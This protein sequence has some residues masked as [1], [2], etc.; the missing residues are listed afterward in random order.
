[1]HYCLRIPEIRSAVFWQLAPDSSGIEGW[2]PPDVRR[3]LAALA[4]TCKAFSDG[5]LDV[6]WSRQTTLVPFMKCLPPDA[7]EAFED[8]VVSA[9]PAE[10]IEAITVG[11]VRLTRPIEHEEWR[12][13]LAYAFRVRNLLIDFKDRVPVSQLLGYFPPGSDTKIPFPRIMSLTWAVHTMSLL[14]IRLFLSPS[15][16]L[17]ELRLRPLAFGRTSLAWDLEALSRLAVEFQELRIL[18][19]F[20]FSE[21]MDYA[22]YQKIN[23][24]LVTHVDQ[25]KQLRVG[26][27]DLPSFQH[28]TRLPSL[29]NLEVHSSVVPLDIVGWFPPTRTTISR[30]LP[31]ASLRRLSLDGLDLPYFLATQLLESAT[32]WALADLD[33][34]NWRAEP[35][36][37][38]KRLHSAISTRIQAETLQSLR[39]GHVESDSEGYEIDEGELIERYAI[40]SD[41]L[42]LLFCFPNL[43]TVALTAPAGFALNTRTV[44]ELTTAWTK[45]TK[46]SLTSSSYGDCHRPTVRGRVLMA[47]AQNCRALQTLDIALD[48]RGTPPVALSRRSFS[49]QTTLAR[50]AFGPAPISQPREIARYLAYLFPNLNHNTGISVSEDWD[51]L[52]GDYDE[53]SRDT[54]DDF[55]EEEC[56]W[57]WAWQ[58]VPSG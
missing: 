23:S 22:L 20:V 1:M 26:L 14:D 48:M 43:E 41:T 42:S 53:T 21:G 37:N 55:D 30:T 13:P 28:L 15:S 10:G 6:L 58:E 54:P 4:R 24:T 47:F 16:Y 18:D 29:H 36:E 8:E 51:E 35:R 5:A 45:L 56:E 19:I 52:Y 7:W 3:D 2:I 25:V 9:D 40:D 12:R 39:V 33:I 31:A 11:S 38:M 57:F 49:A 50:I 27:L 17:R 44:Q 32:G 46:L 34:A